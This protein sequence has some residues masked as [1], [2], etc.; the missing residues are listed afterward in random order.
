MRALAEQTLLGHKLA[1]ISLGLELSQLPS[2]RGG[3]Y[4]QFELIIGLA[5]RI[6][7]GRSCRQGA[8]LVFS[9]L[10]YL[11]ESLP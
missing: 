9:E 1:P 10:A 7:P 6:A 5:K 3:G 2:P 11:Q 8:L 4:Q